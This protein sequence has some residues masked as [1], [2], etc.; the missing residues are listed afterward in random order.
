[1]LN[2]LKIFIVLLLSGFLLSQCIRPQN[3]SETSK[4]LQ[5]IEKVGSQEMLIGLFGMHDPKEYEYLNSLGFN[6]VVSSANQERLDAA[7]VLGMKF[8][9]SC[10]IHYSSEESANSV[11]ESLFDFDSHPSLH[12]WYLVDEPAFNN[13]DPALIIQAKNKLQSLGVTK[14]ISITSWRTEKLDFYQSVADH[15]M[16]DRYPIPWKPVADLGHHVRMGK[17]AAGPSRPVYAI[18]QAFSW[19]AFPDVITQDFVPR[20]PTFAELNAM[21]FDAIAQGAEGIIFFSYKSGNWS[22]PQHPALWASTQ[23]VVDKVKKYQEIFLSERSWVGFRQKYSDFSKRFNEFGASSITTRFFEVSESRPSGDFEPGLYL[24]AVNTT[25]FPH[26]YSIRLDSWE[27]SPYTQPSSINRLNDNKEIS[28][29]DG[30]LT[31]DFK[32]LHVRIY[33]PFIP[34]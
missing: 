22:L 3:N 29:Q 34:R 19:E 10:G 31:D 4:Q 20:S 1:M 2:C 8:I 32:P 12:S 17:L 28:I 26:T 25:N 14:P 24:L 6:T 23:V 33:G 7:E 21:V 15:I 30:W 27:K 13:I 5:Q 16:V 9:S 18:V 11:N